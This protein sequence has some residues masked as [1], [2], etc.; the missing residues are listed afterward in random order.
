MIK[1]Q[2]TVKLMRS[3]TA[4]S[5][6][7]ENVE[8]TIVVV[9]GGD[10]AYD[11]TIAKFSETQKVRLIEPTTNVVFDLVPSDSVSPPILYRIGWRRGV[12]GKLVTHDFYMPNQDI[13]F[14]DIKTQGEVPGS[15]NVTEN[16]IGRAGWVP[17]LDYSGNVLDGTGS[18]LATNDRVNTEISSLRKD[19]DSKD[20]NIISNVTGIVSNQTA[21]LRNEL[22]SRIDSTNSSLSESIDNKTSQLRNDLSETINT[23]K[24][25]ADDEISSLKQTTGSIQ[26]AVSNLSLA[27]SR[28]NTALNK[29]AD[30]VD[31]KV[32]NNQL[33][34][35][36]YTRVFNITDRSGL[37]GLT[38]GSVGDL[39]ITPG[40]TYVLAE[41]PPTT[42]GNWQKL[43]ATSGIQAVNNKTG[44]SVTITTEDLPDFQGKIDTLLN[45]KVD[46]DES[47]KVPYSSLDNIVVKYEEGALKDGNG[48]TIRLSN[49][50]S[51]NGQ[52]GDV[53]I[54]AEGIGAR[55]SGPISQAEVVGL[56][57]SL[58]SKVNS[59][60]PRLTDSRT[61]T[62]HAATHKAGGS[63]PLTLAISQI[64]GLVAE[65]EGKVTQNDLT[66]FKK[67]IEQSLPE[68]PEQ[69]ASAAREFAAVSLTAAK[70]ST[71]KAELAEKYLQDIIARLR[72]FET[73]SGEK[74]TEINQLIKNIE[75]IKA[76]VT[77]ERNVVAADLA[78]SKETLGLI[79]QA[80]SSVETLKSDV[81]SLKE[82]VEASQTDVAGKLGEVKTSLAAVQASQADVTASKT[83]VDAAKKAID[84]TKILIDNQKLAVD[85]AKKAFDVEKSAAENTLS[86]ARETLAGVTTERQEV[87]RLKDAVDSQ[88]SAVDQAKSA[89]D[90]S[91][92]TFNTTVDDMTSKYN[93][94][95]TMHGQAKNYDQNARENANIARQMNAKIQTVKQ[96]LENK[97]SKV[98]EVKTAFD[99]ASGAFNE[100]INKN[101]SDIA[102]IKENGK[103]G[104]F[105]KEPLWKNRRTISLATYYAPDT[106]SPKKNWDRVL[107]HNPHI[108]ISIINVNSG[109][110]D[111]INSDWQAQAEKAH[112]SGSHVVGYV[113]SGWGT[114][115]QD[116]LLAEMQKYI[117][118]YKVD[119]VFVDEAVNGWGDQFN[120]MSY[121][122]EF[123]K[124]IKAKFGK[125]FTVVL[126]PG[127]NTREEMMEAGDVFMIFEN[128]AHKFLKPGDN[129]TIMPDYCYKYPAHKFW[130]L[131]HNVDRTNFVNIIQ[132]MAK[133]NFG[134]LGLTDDRFVDS[135]DP[136]NPAQNPYDDAPSDWVLDIN[137]A[138]AAD[139]FG[140]S[141][142]NRQ[143]ISRINNDLVKRIEDANREISGLTISLDDLK[144]KHEKLKEEY[145]VTKVQ[146][147]T[148]SKG[149]KDEVF[150]DMGISG[151]ALKMSENP[152]LYVSIKAGMMTINANRLCFTQTGDM[153]IAKF[154][155]KEWNGH[156]AIPS[157][158]IVGAVYSW[159]SFKRFIVRTNGEVVVLGAV[160]NEIYSGT[161]TYP[162]NIFKKTEVI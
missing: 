47:G 145:V 20:I 107:R 39:A 96:E 82:S 143:T 108:G 116:K 38:G 93:E 97:I 88:K 155:N 79:N 92:N 69:Q 57:T 32:P 34:D 115:S 160:A 103:V 26:T 121:Y 118:W 9:N 6:K 95:K 135:G 46:K 90:N 53:M 149:P 137:A 131:I 55:R 5:R 139:S 56:G 37:V 51:V 15:R 28:T 129:Y 4:V 156:V 109:P 162:M 123:Y 8:V 10:A 144:K 70:V 66:T 11:S 67:A 48:S 59:N 71:D 61:P 152:K 122:L 49:V 12:S 151:G 113:R 68:N 125:K 63:D 29:K 99:L 65:L 62:A 106:I 2:L 84:G 114:E 146:A 19:I 50:W 91:L 142:W 86:K 111:K 7:P 40:A 43:S 105:E 22:S 117:D 73:T 133:Y 120:K 132:E 147:D 31:G 77:K 13:E 64:E 85:N 89:V 128:F 17:R 36:A 23:N 104:N 158:E 161:I 112:A 98:D 18:S 27:S 127:A 81:S 102:D 87:S 134:H 72:A 58:N 14:D 83:A 119:G 75:A 25:L 42:E 110:G 35:S 130:A 141:D 80:K 94:V 24:Q 148:L 52:T 45:K 33:P 140:Y 74:I 126:N 153:T 157:Q 3:V 41:M 44:S 76:D 154:N 16:D 124:K 100:K 21:S 138:W 1:K 136:R 30:L 54:T 101:I 78:S 159:N 150:L 60:D